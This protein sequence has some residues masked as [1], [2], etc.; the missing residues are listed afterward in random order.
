MTVHS[1]LAP[2]GAPA[3]QLPK[4]TSKPERTRTLK[5][6]SILVPTFDRCRKTLWNR[7]AECLVTI[8][9]VS[10]SIEV[11]LPAPTSTDRTQAQLGVPPTELTP[12]LV[13]LL[14]SRTLSQP[15]N[16]FTPR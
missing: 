6:R 11:L 14:I 3:C 10:L 7:A 4:V 8:L 12:Q 16:L 13:C 5:A 1:R 15:I 9:T 2:L